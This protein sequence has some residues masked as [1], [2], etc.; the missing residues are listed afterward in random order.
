MSEFVSQIILFVF[1]AVVLFLGYDMAHYNEPELAIAVYGLG[2][3]LIALAGVGPST[4]KTLGAKWGKDGEQLGLDRYQATEKEQKLVEK[5]SQDK[6]SPEI[7]KEGQK[8]IE[9]AEERPPEKRSVEDY[10]ALAADKWR[11]GDYDAALEDVYAGLALKP[12]D[13]RIKATL[14]HRK[15][16]NFMSLG[17][18]EQAEKFFKEAIKIDPL[19]SW[20]HNN[21]GNLFRNQGKEKEAEAEYKKALELDPGNADAHNNLGALYERQNKFEL[22]KQQFERALKIDPDHEQAKRSLE[23]VIK[24]LD[25]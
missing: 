21:L 19:F 11:A 10:L 6:P 17:S 15:A 13:I 2:G 4:I 14:V 20:P 5:F 8:F 23:R 24:K 25:E 9:K 16:N 1:G 3:L 7:E 22:A 18:Q 12:E